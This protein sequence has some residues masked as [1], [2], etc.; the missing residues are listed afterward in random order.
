MQRRLAAHMSQLVIGDPD[1]PPRASTWDST[2]TSSRPSARGSD[3]DV[4]WALIRPDGYLAAGT[5]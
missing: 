5:I 4:P 2:A 3:T 1:R